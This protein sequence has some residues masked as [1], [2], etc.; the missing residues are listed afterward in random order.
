[1]EERGVVREEWCVIGGKKGG[2]YGWRR[3][4]EMGV[5]VEEKKDGGKKIRTNG[6]FNNFKMRKLKFM[7]AQEEAAIRVKNLPMPLLQYF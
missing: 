3:K 1:M 4:E 2:T 6:Y 5:S 7:E